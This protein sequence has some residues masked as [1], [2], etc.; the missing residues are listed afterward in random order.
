M[1]VE[2][3]LGIV[4]GC[5]HGIKPLMSRFFLALFG[6]SDRGTSGGHRRYASRTMRSQSFPFQAFDGRGKRTASTV[7]N[8]FHSKLDARTS[9]D[10]INEEDGVGGKDMSPGVVPQSTCAVWA[11]GSGDSTVDVPAHG[12]TYTQQVTIDR[13]SESKSEAGGGVGA[14]KRSRDVDSEVWIMHEH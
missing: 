6:S 13:G 1:I 11:S 14:M 10:E 4:C 5:L 3:N 2:Y 12:I 9:V 7:T 8:P